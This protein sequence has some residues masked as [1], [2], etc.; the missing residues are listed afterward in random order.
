MFPIYTMISVNFIHVASVGVGGG[1]RKTP[2]IICYD[3][4]LVETRN[5]Y[6]WK[7]SRKHLRTLNQK[8]LLLITNP[9]MLFHVFIL[10]S[11]N[12]KTN[13]VVS[14]SCVSTHGVERKW[15]RPIQK[16]REIYKMRTTSV[17]IWWHSREKWQMTTE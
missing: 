12:V 8:L 7:N 14:P 13:F 17:M 3:C 15:R 10:C 9:T 11:P 5:N 1:L 4:S 2:I 16:R 6:T